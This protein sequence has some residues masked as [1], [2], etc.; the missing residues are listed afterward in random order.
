MQYS[1]TQPWGIRIGHR[2]VYHFGSRSLTKLNRGVVAVIAALIDGA[3]KL[4]DM[5]PR[6]NE[7][8]FCL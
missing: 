6:N 7:V 5:F 2:A 1:G 8:S 3:I 4:F